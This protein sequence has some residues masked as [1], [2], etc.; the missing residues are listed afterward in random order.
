MKRFITHNLCLFIGA[1]ISALIIIAYLLSVDLPEVWFGTGYIFELLYQFSIAYCMSYLFY[2]LQVW[3]PSTKNQSKAFA[4]I[5]DELCA[6]SYDLMDVVFLL[7]GC[8]T[9]EENSLSINK[10]IYYFKRVDI[11]N[12]SNGGW[13]NSIELSKES[14]YCIKVSIDKQIQRITTN[15]IYCQNDILLIELI[16]KLQ[17]NNIFSTMISVCEANEQCVRVQTENIRKDFQDYKQV[18]TELWAMTNDCVEVAYELKDS[19]C[20]FYQQRLA[21]VPKL[22]GTPRV[23]IGGK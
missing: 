14:F 10:K 6:L 2:I 22:S 19:E 13:A 18:A 4:I 17:S 15:S 11:S 1:I 5:K 12:E 3:I 7:E 9:I 16:S 21:G 23:F 8:C 20:A